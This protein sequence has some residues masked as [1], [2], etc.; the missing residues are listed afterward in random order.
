MLVYGCIKVYSNVYYYIIFVNF[1]QYTYLLC[2]RVH[3][4]TAVLLINHNY[5]YRS[6]IIFLHNGSRF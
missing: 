3:Y 2:V 5:H 1:I 4:N 6:T